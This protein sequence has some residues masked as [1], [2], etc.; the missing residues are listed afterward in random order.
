M[1]NR[2]DI[3]QLFKAHYKQMRRVASALLH[4][5]D[6]ARDAVHD[7]FAS[8]LSGANSAAITPGYLLT[9][10]R[11]RCLNIIRDAEI[12]LRIA[13]LYFLD[14][15]DYDA[16]DWPD[17]ATIA[18][19]YDIIK[20]ELTPQCRRVMELRFQDGLTFALVAETLGISQNAV[21]KHV[22]QA[23]LIIRKNLSENG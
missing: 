2:N 7:V 21:Y 5:D 16:E 19:V 23:L 11:N 8:L 1:T 10:V 12:R 22:R 18:R 17:D 6:T 4:D 14:S 15:E 13:N 3:E 9:A 20:S